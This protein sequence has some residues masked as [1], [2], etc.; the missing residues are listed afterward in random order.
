MILNVYK[1]KGWTS[2]DVVAKLRSILHIKKI[3]HAGTL[4]PLAEGVLVVL[5]NEDTKKQSDFLKL[6]K[7]YIAEIAF[8]LQSKTYDLEGPPIF[9][10][11]EI[12]KDKLDQDFQKIINNYIGEIP[13]KV[14]PY[15]A[16]KVKGQKLYKKAR[17]QNINEIE[18]PVKKVNIYNIEISDKYERVFEQNGASKALP[19][20][21]VKMACSS[22]TYIRS[23]AHDLGKDLGVD[24]I[25]AGLLRTRIGSY[26]LK[27]SKRVNEVADYFFCHTSH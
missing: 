21:K 2:F 9:F 15:S 5:T 1:E 11:G 25:L 19:V 27:D 26:E 13:Q 18:L 10:Q 7:E 3:G 14:P 22:G 23:L 8:G 20:Y 16:V 4:D 6:D 12:D 17:K 24:G